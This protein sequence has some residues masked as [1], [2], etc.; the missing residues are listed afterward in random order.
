MTLEAKGFPNH[1]VELHMADMFFPDL[2]AKTGAHT[3]AHFNTLDQAN[4]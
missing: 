2:Y 4:V 3:H 1:G